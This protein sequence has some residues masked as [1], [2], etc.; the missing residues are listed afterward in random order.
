[1]DRNVAIFAGVALAAVTVAATVFVIE[2]GRSPVVS[3][4]LANLPNGGQPRAT[5]P[6]QT[7]AIAGAAAMGAMAPGAPT[8]APAVQLLPDENALRAYAA[9]NA[10]GAQAEQARQAAAVPVPAQQEGAM[11]PTALDPIPGFTAA[12]PRPGGGGQIAA[13][14]APARAA[15]P[16]SQQVAALETAWGRPGDPRDATRT[17]EIDI[18][19]LHDGRMWFDPYV[20]NLQLGEQVRIIIKNTGDFPHAFVIATPQEIQRYIADV[21]DKP[22]YWRGDANW[23]WVMPTERGELVWQ[24]TK[25]GSFEFADVTPGRRDAGL[26][27]LINVR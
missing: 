8:A 4:V 3:D 10:L 2:R 15:A 13:D 6:A 7:Y 16:A 17:F 19:E 25:A 12:P 21:K 20:L 5:P 14:P 26:T 23:V 11:A 18:R 27:G 24:F 22:D 9:M 1:M